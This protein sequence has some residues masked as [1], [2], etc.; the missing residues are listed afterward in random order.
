MPMNGGMSGGSNVAQASRQQNWKLYSPRMYPP[1]VGH[2]VDTFDDI[3]PE[4]V[5]MNGS[6]VF[7]PQ[8]DF[9]CV[10][11]MSWTDNGQII[12]VRYLPE[13]NE[14]QA[15]PLAQQSPNVGDLSK[16]FEM[17][18]SHVVDKLDAFEKR[19]DDIYT[20]SQSRQTRS[21]KIDKEDDAS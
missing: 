3:A 8:S 10:Y 20:V 11:G 12:P 6:M 14:P 18:A 7:F 2:W 16:G 5:P 17:F 9:S 19:L 1:V 13:R 4:D 15:P 21:R